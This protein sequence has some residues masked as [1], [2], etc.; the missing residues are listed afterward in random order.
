[1]REVCLDVKIEP[2]LLPNYNPLK[3]NNAGKARL[4]VSGIGVWAPQE[5]TFVDVR[6][7]HP[8]A[9]SYVNSDIPKLYVRWSVGLTD[10]HAY[11][12]SQPPPST[13]Y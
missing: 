13:R 6:I 5:R 8:N 12:Q 11:K 9:P 4:D 7:F 10:M 1:M 3:G 2:E